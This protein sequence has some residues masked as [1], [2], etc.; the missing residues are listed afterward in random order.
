MDFVHYRAPNQRD[1]PSKPS[2]DGKA[3]SDS[4]LVKETTTLT[5]DASNGQAMTSK[6]LK[7]PTATVTEV[8]EDPET[9]TRPR[10]TREQADLFEQHFQRHYK[11]NSNMKRQL[12]D[13][14]GLPLQRVAVS[15][16]NM[17]SCRGDPGLT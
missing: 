8:N 6:V 13:M 10:L 7:S 15:P 12:A 2:T 3:T 9:S 1:E 5:G 14:T 11:P 17:V 16:L 4:R